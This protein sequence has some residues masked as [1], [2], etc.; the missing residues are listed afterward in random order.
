MISWPLLKRNMASCVKPFLIIF[1][2]MCLYIAVIVYM[3]KPEL[4]AMLN[5]YQKA[6]P[7]MM[8][9]VGMAGIAGNL[10][11]WMQIYLYGFIMLLFPLIF[12]IILIQ[13][14]LMGYIDRGSMANLLA[15]PNS[16]G[17]VIRTQA[18][19]AI[20][21]IFI[22]MVSITLA[23]LVSAE[24]MFPGELDT[25]RYLSLNGSTLLLQL[26]ITGI[27]F[28]AACLFTES[29]YYYAAGAGIPILFFLIQLIAN[30]GDKLANLKY[31]TLYS[32]LKSADI[33]KGN[34]VFLENTALFLIGAALYGCGIWYFQKRDL[35]I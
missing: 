29:K 20:L 18:F 19:S 26:A 28:L 2:V 35:A 10:L 6:L 13:K 16:R 14:L 11:E 27:A 5:D 1:A 34:S 25:E 3:Y 15:T 33:I 21:W 23:G 17:K 9:A 32:L 7:G 22:L 24:A 4:A 31:I 8:S 30:M 12:I